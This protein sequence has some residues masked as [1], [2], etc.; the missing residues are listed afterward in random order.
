[1]HSADASVFHL[2]LLSWNVHGPPFAPRRGAR[3]AAVAN[4]IERRA[5]ELV[6]LQEVWF[7][8]DADWL[9]TRLSRRYTALDGTPRRRPLR[10]GGLFGLLR[11]DAPWVLDAR[12]VAFEWYRA[13]ASRWRLWEG[14]GAAGKGVQVVPLMHRDSGQPLVALHTHVQAQYDTIRHE[15][16]RAQQLEQLAMLAATLPPNLPVL[17]AG[18]LNTGPVEAVYGQR[19]A[20]TWLDL[21]ETTRAARPA[22]QTQFECGAEPL[23]ID[24]VLARRGPSWGFGAAVDLVENNGRDDPFSDHNGLH[25][26]IEMERLSAADESGGSHSEGRGGEG[27]FAF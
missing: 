8:G 20:P 14:D 18:D 12:G 15:A 9:A 13:A 4:E 27:T 21:T 26:R 23:W 6:L 7:P 5:P 10:V 17:A 22:A 11:R 3:I 24:Y 19:I 1:M 2:D 16:P 25:A